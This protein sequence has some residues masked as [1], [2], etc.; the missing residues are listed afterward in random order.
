MLCRKS[1]F[2]G[3]TLLEGNAL[4]HTKEKVLKLEVIFLV[5][6]D[7][8]KGKR[9]LVFS[10]GVSQSCLLGT[11]GMYAAELHAWKKEKCTVGNNY[12]ISRVNNAQS[13]VVYRD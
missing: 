11:H 9:T 10:L 8:N 4:S 12:I 6:S 5:D 1:Q 2:S 13:S 3:P 7:F